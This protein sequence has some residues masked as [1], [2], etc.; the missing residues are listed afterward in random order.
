MA[1]FELFG[2]KPA[3]ILST[4]FDVSFTFHPL[5]VSAHKQDYAEVIITLKNTSGE[6]QLTSFIIAV[7]HGLGFESTGLSQERELR[8]GFL[9]AG[10]EKKFKV[11]IYSNQ[12]T[13][14]GDYI[15]K[16]F[17]AAHY[18]NYGYVANELR[19]SFTL[20]AV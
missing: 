7:P 3:P 5:R 4:P 12:R 1:L 15:V 18:R 13:R 17:A 11:N 19:K 20:R 16:M 14:P 9:K 8:L 6:E 2:K 10:E